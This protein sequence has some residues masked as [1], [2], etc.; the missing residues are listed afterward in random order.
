MSKFLVDC[1]FSL[2]IVGVDM[3]RDCEELFVIV[4]GNGAYNLLAT[5]DA[6]EESSSVCVNKTTFNV[7]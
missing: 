4:S 7:N 5:I 2:G 3:L 1:G 6:L